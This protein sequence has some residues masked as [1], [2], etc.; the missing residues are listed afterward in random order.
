MGLGIGNMILRFCP[1]YCETGGYTYKALGWKYTWNVPFGMETLIDLMGGPEATE[2]RLGTM[3]I[4]GLKGSGVGEGQLNGVGS[5]FFNPGNEPSFATPFLYN[6][7]PGRQ[8]KSVLRSRE[9]VNQYY[10]NGSSG[11]PGNSDAGA[12][13]SWLVWQ[14]VGLY[15]AVTQ[16]VYLILAPMFLHLSLKVGLEGKFLNITALGLSDGNIYIQSL[17]VNGA[18]WNRS[19]LS[20]GNIADGGSL[21]F[22]LGKDP[23]Y[24]ILVTCT[25]ARGTSHFTFKTELL[26]FSDPDL[27][28]DS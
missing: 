11:L 16:P 25:R 18:A 27:L 28:K 3:F 5:T 22:I 4:E 21:E 24:G 19:W 8:H 1:G 13:D 10:R 15:P 7:L 9:S 20:H 26:N 2:A 17:T 23:S 12:L 6:Y 14:M